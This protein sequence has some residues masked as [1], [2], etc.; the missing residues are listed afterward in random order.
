MRGGE[1]LKIERGGKVRR[2]AEF[3]GGALQKPRLDPEHQRLRLA[4]PLK[5]HRMPCRREAHLARAVLQRMRL[6]A[7]RYLAVQRLKKA[8][9]QVL[10]RPAHVPNLARRSA[11][12]LEK[13]AGPAVRAPHGRDRRWHMRLD[14]EMRQS[15]LSGHA[16][17]RPLLAQPRPPVHENA[18]PRRPR[19]VA[20]EFGFTV[21]AHRR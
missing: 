1:F 2:G 8:V 19:P 14:I 20:R 7:T 12:L 15:G 10:P 21:P 6:A 13:K 3:R 4:H 17:E 16:R 11:P 9:E 18:G 5:C